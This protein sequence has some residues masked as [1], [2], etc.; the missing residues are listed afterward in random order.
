[1]INRTVLALFF[2]AS[3]L[4][5]PIHIAYGQERQPSREEIIDANYSGP[6]F[7]D[8]YWTSGSS[9][10]D[11]TEIDVAPGDGA[12]TLAVVL[13]NRGP[14]DISSI[15]GTLYLP[16]GF[17]ASGRPPGASAL[18]TF[19]QLARVGNPF[20]LF[21]DVDVLENARIGE[22]TAR[23]IVEYSRFF[24][25]GVPRTAQMDVVFRVTGEAIVAV[26][27]GSATGDA[28]NSNSNGNQ[29]TAGKFENYTFYVANMGTAPITNVV[30]RIQSQ[31]DSLKILGDSKWTIRRIEP[32]SQVDLATTV[33]AAE[34]LIGSPVSLDVIVEYSSNGQLSTETFAVGTYV[35]GEINIRAY[36]IDITYIGGTPNIVGNLLNEGNTVALFTTI[37]LLRAE[38]LVSSLPQSQYLGDLEENSPLPFSIPIAV[39]NNSSAGTY[40]VSLRITYKDSLRDIHTLDI[41]TEVQFMPE[42]QED[43]AAQNNSTTMVVPVGA[44]VA[45]AAAIGGAM[46]YLQRKRSALRLNFQATK[47][48]D[49]ESV[50]DRHMNSS[51]SE[52]ED[53]K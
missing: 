43:G 51:S 5:I 47:Q 25:T 2:A 23:L 44:G 3:L 53:G 32:D 13:V 49:I 15:T 22:H 16:P 18:A 35:A 46:V 19:N 20:V 50:L 26:G 24:E 8:A 21:F 29:I 1:M 48:D 17:Q 30:V 31:S 33:F 28:D 12:S 10:E 42:Q 52:Q 6:V 39:D 36:E 7:L 38:N 40:P 27:R 41:N 9:F 37:E 45:A 4:F 14:S 34:T 11:G